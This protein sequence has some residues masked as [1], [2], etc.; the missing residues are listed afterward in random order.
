MAI[1]A[2]EFQRDYPMFAAR[3]VHRIKRALATAALEFGAD[4]CG[5]LHDQIVIQ[6]TIVDLLGD[7][8]GSPTSKTKGS[9]LREEAAARLNDLVLGLP[10]VRGLSLGS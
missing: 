9:T 2:A 7:T 10:G 6:A 1:T 8:T 5:D 4:V 3:S